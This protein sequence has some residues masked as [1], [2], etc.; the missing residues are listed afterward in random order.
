ME[1]YTKY[2]NQLI[3]FVVTGVEFDTDDFSGGPPF[4]VLLMMHPDGTE[5]RVVV[6][7]DEEENSAGFLFVEE[8]K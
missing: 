7:S 2:Y 5:V 1:F 4:P 3:D 6:S 8:A